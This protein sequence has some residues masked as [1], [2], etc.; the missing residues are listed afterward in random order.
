M[1]LLM[2][3]IFCMTTLAWGVEVGNVIV[4]EV[5]HVV[6]IYTCIVFPSWTS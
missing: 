1:K 3:R 6:C 2:V 5:M 4:F